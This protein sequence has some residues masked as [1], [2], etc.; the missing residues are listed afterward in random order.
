[1]QTAKIFTTGR[2]QAVRL[3]K[4]FQFD[5]REVFI[6]HF[7]G[8]VLLIPKEKSWQSMAE[9]VGEFESDFVLQREAQP[10]QSREEIL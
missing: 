9:A 6:K 3:P 2:S 4:A 1:M 8:G 5:G 7:A 10:E